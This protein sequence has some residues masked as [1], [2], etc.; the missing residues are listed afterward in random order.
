MKKL[1]LPI[2]LGMLLLTAAPALAVENIEPREPKV[3]T[4]KT[5]A[6]VVREEQRPAPKPRTVA[7]RHSA[8]ERFYP[9]SRLVALKTETPAPAL[10]AEPS[11]V[12]PTAAELKAR[13]IA[14]ARRELRRRVLSIIGERA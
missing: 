8:S 11:E 12:K 14:D 6:L 13:R 4:P 5:P 7:R 9:S 2:T 10:N 1:M 3:I